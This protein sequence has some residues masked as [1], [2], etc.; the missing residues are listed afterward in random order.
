[1]HFAPVIVL[2]L[3]A[4]SQLS[5]SP[6]HE[7]DR[8]ALLKGVSEISTNGTPGGLSAFG[9]DAFAVVAGKESPSA[10]LPVAAA[11]RW[12]KGRIVAFGHDGF[13]RTPDES[14]NGALLANIAR[15]AS[16]DV[17]KPK[18]GVVR[19]PIL[20]AHLIAN[21]FEVTTL[22]SPDW[23]SQLA[24][25]HT[26]FIN[27][28]LISAT[29]LP[30]LEKHVR[31][32]GGF[33]TGVTGWGW[34]Q[35]RGGKD[36]SRL[37]T[38][39]AAN[40]LI[41]R[42]GLAFTAGIRGRTLPASY[43]A[44][45]DLSLLNA[46]TALRGIVAHSDGKTNATPAQLAQCGATLA[47]AIRSLPP[48]DE[49]LLPKLAE[50]VI[51]PDGFP[52][53]A[54]PVSATNPL[55]RLALTLDME[56][57]R[58][59]PPEKI[60]PHPAST[61]FPGAVA[62][63]VPRVADR[64]FSIDLSVPRWHSTGYYAAPGDVIQIT[65][66]AGAAGQ[67]LG[68]RIGCHTDTLWHLDEWKRAPEISRRDS[69]DHPQTL[70]ASPFGGLIYLDVPDKFPVGTIEVT[71]SGAV[72]AP[73]FILGKT[74][75]QDWADR[76]RHLPGPWAELETEKIILSVPSGKIRELDDPA[77]LLTFWDRVLDAQADLAATPRER[78][79]PERIVPD[80]QIS[81]GYMHSGY[82][83]MTWLDHSVE[84]SLSAEKLAAGSWG[85]FHELGHNHQRPD[86]TFDGTVEVT[87]NL[88]TLYTTE[89]V[90]GL[91]P[92]EGHDAMEPGLVE[93]RLRS[94]LSKPDKFAR[95]K[96]D[97][98]LAL[99][100][101]FQLRTAFGWE[102]YKAVFAEYRDL[103]ASERPKSEDEKRDQWL[104]RFS[105][106]AG[107]NLG[108]FFEAWGV[109]TTPAARQSVADLPAWMPEDWPQP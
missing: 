106:A 77:A 108:P 1:M 2:A 37:A 39:C 19:E 85:H 10:L 4:A 40:L 14:D 18:I 3:L 58:G 49:I 34:I 107:R 101:Y 79:F 92:G 16:G 91:P 38:E 90:C 13:L 21:G 95:W 100:M 63:D 105:R 31:S 94:H 25:I 84:T 23:A 60:R 52:T 35:I 71:L 44:G 65:V 28:L 104:V 109:P 45:G 22:E 54:N 17:A 6:A 82:P 47:D 51:P 29:D 102:T 9:P 8:A 7:A 69:L 11:A 27:G 67:G 96:S 88:F 41:Q 56:R 43:A 32:G 68:V 87:C 83:I 75:L 57:L 97:P 78:K 66:P 24:A 5:A 48:G 26:V 15:W 50:I 36:N 59:T 64:T 89:T 103:P 33:V 80:A 81:A 99:T 86:W 98:F 30:L 61:S 20:A 42:A 70:T 74:D 62:V 76:I 53:P 12:D 73:R 46:T 55:A 93:S 72:E